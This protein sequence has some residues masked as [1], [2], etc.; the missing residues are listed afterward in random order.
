MIPWKRNCRQEDDRLVLE[1]AEAIER[2]LKALFAHIPPHVSLADE[3]I[4]ERREE[5][6]REAEK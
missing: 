5:A 3:L 6:T 1:K 4:A 2:R